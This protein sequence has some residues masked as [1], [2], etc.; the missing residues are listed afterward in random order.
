MTAFKETCI[1]GFVSKAVPVFHKIC[2]FHAN[3]FQWWVGELRI[4][5]LPCAFASGN[6]LASGSI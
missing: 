4:W 3:R 6:I 5:M 2:V 1:I